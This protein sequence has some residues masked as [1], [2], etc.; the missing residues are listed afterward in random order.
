MI[1]PAI[2]KIMAIATCL[3][4]LTNTNTLEAQDADTTPVLEVSE[5]K[6]VKPFRI[7]TE[8]K[9]ITI[10]SNHDIQRIMVWGSNGHRFIE[11]TNVNSPSYNFIVPPKEKFVFLM[12]QLKNG[13]HYTEKIGVQ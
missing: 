8:G 10:Q 5:K 7:L 1:H 13:K 4:L 3:C 9:K 2:F 6:T 12:I 11:Q